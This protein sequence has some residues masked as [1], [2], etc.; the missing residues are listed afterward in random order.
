MQRLTRSR[1]AG[2]S[3]TRWISGF[4]IG[5]AAGAMFAGPLASSA[6]ADRPAWIVPG[7]DAQ[8]GA[9]RIQALGCA[10]C[11]EVPGVKGANG[12]VGPPLT[13][14]GD[15]TY[16]A[17]MLSNTPSN[18]VKWIREPQSVVPGNAMPNMGI[19]EAEARDIA[20]YLYTLR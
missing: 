7:G 4:A 3:P 15:R 11:H 13:R 14:F 6:H 5:V 19:S 1:D 12:N 18:L 9:K 2:A 8:R 20:A 10:G 17:G 16:I